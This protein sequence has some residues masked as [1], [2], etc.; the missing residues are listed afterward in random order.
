MRSNKTAK[1]KGCLGPVGT[2]T[3]FTD[4]EVAHTFEPIGPKTMVLNAARLESVDS[5]GERILLSIDNI[6]ERKTAE[7]ALLENE[8][9]YRTWFNLSPMAVYTVDASGVILNFNRHAAE[10][11]RRTPALG[12]TD[13]RF[14]G[15]FKMFRPDGSFM[16]HEQC[17]M[18][19]VV[20]GKVSG[21][22]NGEVL[23]ERPDGSHVT[24]LVNIR[25]LKNDQG[26]VT[27]AINWFY[28]I[29]ERK[30]M[31]E[32]L[33]NLMDKEKSAR[34]EAEAGESR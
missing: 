26:E 21:V 24:V 9:R 28:D 15:S 34:A 17:P 8:E 32:E 31:E 33:K 27:G 30:Q 6:T 29:T 4:F 23:I 14:C 10:L 2:K 1:E 12:E 13:E 16:P 7:V 20:S 3:V 11:W 25:P 18:A 19:D 5:T 22:H